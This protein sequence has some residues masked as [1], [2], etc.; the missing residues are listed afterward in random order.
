M[1]S[2]VTVDRTTRKYLSR[3]RA[4]LQRPLHAGDLA[5]IDQVVVIP[6]FAEQ[7][8]LFHT[9][10]SLSLSS[11]A[12]LER[13]LVLCVVNNRQPPHAGPGGIE[14]NARTL[15][16]LAGLVGGNELTNDGGT[17]RLAYID[18]SSPGRE[19]GPR[20]GVGAARRIGLDHA[21]AVLVENGAVDALLLSLD[22]DCRVESGYLTAV[23]RHFEW[24]QAHAGVVAYAHRLEGSS[25]EIA[26]IVSYE[27]F[28][29]YHASGLAWTH[30]PYA[31]PAIGSTMVCRK[32]AYVA[33]GGMNRRQAAE[34][35]Y[36]LQQLQKTGGVE[37]IT[38]TTV[39]PSARS[40]HRVPFGTGATVRRLLV[41]GVSTYAVYNPEV[42]PVL[43][44]WLIIVGEGLNLAAGELLS[45]ADELFPGLRRH[46]DQRGFSGVWPRLQQHSKT[47]EQLRS[48]FHRWFDGLETLKLIHWLRDN[49]LPRQGLSN[50]LRR[51]V[52]LWGLPCPDVDWQL[53]DGDLETRID[54]LKQLR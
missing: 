12:D 5:A 30:S 49:G 1:P 54:V 13:T 7:D 32:E 22:A 47:E 34:D 18:A 11:P 41:E 40:S 9:L 43:R 15:V 24:S 52:E 3:N 44:E 10:A 51:A 2:G 48:Q 39:R 26:A 31:Y 37:V 19:L 45:R 16:K 8:F 50:V 21:L 42:Y 35:F 6:A 23:R 28:L 17:L 25:R 20:M 4:S 46:L 29:R 33:V 27:L 53:F 38:G 36:F 14:N